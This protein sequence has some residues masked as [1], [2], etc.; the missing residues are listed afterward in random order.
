VRLHAS[1][2]DVELPSVVLSSDQF[3]GGEL[4]RHPAPLIFPADASGQLAYWF[5]IETT[6]GETL[7]H[8]NWGTNFYM[9]ILPGVHAAQALQT[10]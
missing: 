7:W 2:G 5:E 9:P 8:S 1:V 10:T 4:I 3:H 6:T